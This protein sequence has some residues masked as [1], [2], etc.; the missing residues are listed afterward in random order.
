MKTEKYFHIGI[1]V[2]DLE[3]AV[4]RF[5]EVMGLTFAEPITA[6]FAS[7]EDPEPHPSFVRCTYSCGESPHIELLEAN[8][9][10][11][12][13]IKQGE[14]IHHLGIWEADTAGRCA[15]LAAASVPIGARVVQPD[16]H[17]MT[18]FN[19]P[20]ALHGIRLEFLDDSSRPLMDE[21]AATGVF[22]GEASI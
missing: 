5:S 9:D 2:R 11:L 15:V 19:D 13:T 4:K 12:F 16:G 18:V 17:I 3:A 21:W 22:P 10:G 20:A 1:L 8:G 7:L 6:T 14:G